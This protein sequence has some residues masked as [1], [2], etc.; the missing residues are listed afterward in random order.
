MVA[1][2]NR[3]MVEMRNSGYNERYRKETLTS[4]V[5]GY[6]RKVEEEA[7][8]RRPL[9]KEASDGARERY[10]GKISASSSWFQKKSEPETTMEDYHTKGP[11]RSCLLYTSPSP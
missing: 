11:S 3:Y 6:R 2:V 5:K 1:A 7:M 10:L 9:Y 4:A 8:G